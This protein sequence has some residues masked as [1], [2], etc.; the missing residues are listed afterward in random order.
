[1]P[2]EA[3]PYLSPWTPKAIS[4]RRLDACEK[5]PAAF[6]LGQRKLW[7][8]AD[9]QRWA[10]A[11]FPDRKTF[12]GRAGNS[13]AQTPTPS[14]TITAPSVACPATAAQSAGH[15]TGHGSFKRKPREQIG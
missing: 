9:L 4:G 12:E 13:P 7:R 5:C 15:R 14:P 10:D 1:M 8:V 6:N 11:G 2:N 3:P